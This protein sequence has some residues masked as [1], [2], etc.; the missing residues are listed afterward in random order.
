[1]LQG[2]S[3][4]WN[5]VGNM[6]GRL[7]LG[8]MSL[9][10]VPVFVHLLG[11]NAFG[12]VSLVATF[13]SVLALLDFGLAGT[14]NREVATL[15][16]AGN[17]GQIADTV[18]TFEVIYWTVA[19]VIGLGFA[20]LS[21]WLANSWVPQQALPPADI[22][23]AILLGGLA[24][25]ARWPVALYTG[26]LQG[27]ERQVVQNG[28]LVVTATTRAG[29]TI[30][31][32][33]FVSRTVYCF[34]VTQALANGLEVLLSGYVAR[35]LALAG[36][37]GRFDQAVVRRVWRFAVGVNLVGTF[38]M[39]VSGA[40]Q[41]LISKLLPLVELT[42]YS[43][44]STATGAL[45]VVSLAAQTSL[46]PRLSYCWQ[47]QDLGQMRRLYLAGLRF[48]IFACVAP[49]MVLC[50]FPSEVLTLWTRSPELAN[51]VRGV[52]P[53]LA[54]ANLANC[55]S[56]TSYNVVLAT[57]QTRLPVLVNA[58]S[59]PFLV[60]GC[61]LAIRALGL[62]GVAWCWLVYTS[63]Q[64]GVYGR[65]CATRA[66]PAERRQLLYGFPVAFLLVG[67]GVSAISK[68]LL[69]DHLGSIMLALWLF[70]TIIMAYLAGILVLKGE[71]R[72][73]LAATLMQY[74][75]QVRTLAANKK[76][77]SVPVAL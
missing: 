43:V 37:K 12:I 27:L 7:W 76:P 30:L 51:H 65:Y 53:I 40:P 14:A 15:R 3:L 11:T 5:F 20:G 13:Q 1:L 69:P 29:L 8:I 25:A 35:R 55:A 16:A 72:R 58:I 24:F 9:V 59:L 62:C 46:F 57:G 48:T 22:Q 49:A 50:F 67:A 60:V 26:I 47:Q 10:T 23:M 74:G 39:L 75:L 77:R 66:F 56:G 54:L 45:Q 44:A 33:L 71:E 63:A 18:R 73:M 31:A 68:L 52:L 2:S 61:C 70:A 42:Y 38:G 34:L 64:F 17:R 6:T 41:L 21:H 32:L 4:R 36:A 19:V 28:I